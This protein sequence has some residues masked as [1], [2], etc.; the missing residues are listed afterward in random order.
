[1]AR[2]ERMLE[3]YEAG[4]V[5][6]DHEDPPPEVLAF[7]PT[8]PAGRAL[9]LGCGLG[10]AAIFMARLGWQ[11]DGVD[12]IP[13]AIDE[14]RRRAEQTG[15][16]AQAQFHVGSTTQLDFLSDPY[17]F[18]L[19]VGA[20][21]SFSSEE[22][23]AYH[24]EL[25]R[26]LRPGASYLLFAHLHEEKPEQEQRRW[27]DEAELREVLAQGFAL[28]RVEYGET[29]VGDQAPWRSGWFWWRRE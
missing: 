22:L 28:E 6:W 3:L 20:M 26:L 7:V 16:A 1:M 27:L 21:H 8:L 11:V 19:D 24:G 9:D 15:V 14:A 25:L 5:P 23:R 10:R 13:Q 2:Y 4:T 18:A 29:Q 17:D 12:F